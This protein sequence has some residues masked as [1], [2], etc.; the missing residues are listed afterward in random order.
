[1][2]LITCEECQS[3]VSSAATVCPKCGNPITMAKSI[4]ST[5]VPINTI[6]ETSKKFKMQSLL[7]STLMV[8][9]LAV[10]CATIDDVDP[11]TSNGGIVGFIIGFVWYIVN[12]VRIW[13]HHK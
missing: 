6:Q 2:A 13:W 10:G 5:G 12:K 4:K 9:G 1:M 8:L 3:D 11:D 7:S